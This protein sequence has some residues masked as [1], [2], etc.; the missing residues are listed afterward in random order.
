MM[1]R[2]QTGNITQ[3]GGSCQAPEDDHRM[4]ALEFF[5]QRK[6]GT[7]RIHYTD[8]RNEVSN[9]WHIFITTSPAFTALPLSNS[10]H[11]KCD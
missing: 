11:N 9:L 6:I 4:A 7:L 8:L 3:E 2:L 5:P 1:Y 10:L